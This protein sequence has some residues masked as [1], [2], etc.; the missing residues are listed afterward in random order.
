MKYMTD[1]TLVHTMGDTTRKAAL[2]VYVQA[3]GAVR[4]TLDRRTKFSSH[5]GLAL[6]E[7]ALLAGI[8]VGGFILIDKFLIGA[9]G[10]GGFIKKL[11]DKIECSFNNKTTAGCS[12]N[13]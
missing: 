5:R 8:A 7:Y 4:S 6:L 11:T 2:R 10:N 1:R 12:T 9:D 3:Y 13:K